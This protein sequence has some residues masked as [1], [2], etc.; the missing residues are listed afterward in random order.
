MKKQNLQEVAVIDNTTTKSVKTTVSSDAKFSNAKVME[1]EKT[2]PCEV[3]KSEVEKGKS[4]YVTRYYLYQTHEYMKRHG[5]T[6]S[7]LGYLRFFKENYTEITS[8]SNAYTV[9]NAYNKLKRSELALQKEVARLA[10]KQAQKRELAKAATAEII[11]D[12]EIT[13]E[14]KALLI[15]LGLL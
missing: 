1:G 11:K 2:T 3:F 5:V 8:V 4:M 7:W 14:Q 10:K 12:H 9:W 13:E 6:Y 15:Q